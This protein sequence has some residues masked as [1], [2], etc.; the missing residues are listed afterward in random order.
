LFLVAL[1]GCHNEELKEWDGGFEDHWLTPT[2]R[3]ATL[4][5]G[6]ENVW[7][8]DLRVGY[9]A[10]IEVTKS[11]GDLKLSLRSPDEEVEIDWDC[12]DLSGNSYA[13]ARFSWVSDRDGVWRVRVSTP[14][15][16]ASASYALRLARLAP[17]R[18]AERLEW[19]VAKHR[20][21]LGRK[22]QLGDMAGARS[23]FD[24]ALAAKE[25]L[26]ADAP[27]EVAEFLRRSAISFYFAPVASEEPRRVAE[28]LFLRVLAIRVQELGAEDLEVASSH[29]TLAHLYYDLD[30]WSPA[31]EHELRALEIRRRQLPPD[32][33]LIAKSLFGLA[34]ITLRQGRYSS[35]A[36]LIDR[37]LA[38]YLRSAAPDAKSIA[39]CFN[40]KAEVLRIQDAL[41]AAEVAY[42]EGLAIARRGYSDHDRVVLNLLNN[43]A[44]LLKDQ[45]R[46][47]EAE[48]LFRRVSEAYAE[49]A[50]GQPREYARAL[51]NRAELLRL[52]GRYEE[53]LPLYLEALQR[54]RKLFEADDPQL[55]YYLNQLAVQ[56]AAQGRFFAAEPFYREI[57]D[58]RRRS[59]PE[60]HPLTSQSLHDY[61]NLL[62]SLGRYPEAD[63]CYRQAVEIRAEVF[64]PDHPEV[65]CSMIESARNHLLAGESVKALERV[66][67]AIRILATTRSFPQFEIEAL[68]VRATLLERLRGRSAAM[69][70][71]TAALDLVEQQRPQIGG[72]EIN[73][74]QYL[75]LHYELFHRMFVWQ[76]ES[77]DM[78]AAFET[79]ERARARV[80]LDRIVGNRVNLRQE[81]PASV[82]EPLESREKRLKS[83]LVALQQRLDQAGVGD[84]RRDSRR[85]A[86][87]LQ[88]RLDG[89]TRSL[90]DVRRELLMASP[91]WNKV[92]TT[93]GRPVSLAEAQ[94]SLVPADGL[95]LAYRIG[96]ESS[97]VLVIP[98]HPEPVEARKLWFPNDPSA[99]ALP[100]RVALDAAGLE[101]LVLMRELPD[102]EQSTGTVTGQDRSDRAV[103]GQ[104]LSL[105]EKQARLHRLWIT[106]IPEDL[107]PRI[108]AAKEL[109]LVPDGVLHLL[110]F[111][112]LVVNREAGGNVA[113]WLDRG[114]PI[115]YVSSA[116]T[117][118]NL[119]RRSASTVSRNTLLLVSDPLF[120]GLPRL[121]ESVEEAR[122]IRQVFAEREGLEI[123]TLT[124]LDARESRVRRALESQPRFL[125]F[126]T[127]G[128]VDRSR[129]EERAALALTPPPGVAESL[130][131]DGQLQL[132][133]IYELRLQADLA[134]LSAC[135][136][137][138]GR[139]LDGEGVFTLS[140]GFLAA[141]AARVIGSLW[142]VVDTSTSELMA[143]LYR[144]IADAGA[145][146]GSFGYATA[147]R[148]A[149]RTLRRRPEWSDPF[150]WAPFILIG[151][152]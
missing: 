7:N 31:E 56:Y 93:A 24:R 146:G 94:R 90:Q 18:P 38:I 59:L 96:G 4:T 87:S 117:A 29:A 70:S 79:L 72:G 108:L 48:Q 144:R 57:L 95:L 10:E 2:A 151:D 58:V 42:R 28:T 99:T 143:D 89:L 1:A 118:Y 120:D 3:D 12:A 113:Y 32:D 69:P 65:A 97:Y 17:A 35:A 5:F 73:R 36:A 84:R 20:A 21:L 14:A 23:A 88:S 105:S 19:E 50:E 41:D 33:P 44:G 112:A 15:S 150:Y 68:A 91:L 26:A 127:H 81:I 53:A 40:L 116:T 8:L 104:R 64:G 92:I 47:A 11:S 30:L 55:I 86:R 115:R 109:V 111:E 103:A 121:R 61:G 147:L 126:A 75:A 6:E 82:R 135:E 125:H 141:G 114:P 43:L 134:V 60:V 122:R 37:A 110:P 98:P 145:A 149:K 16:A 130:E 85:E 119:L 78:P 107:R 51:L 9:V 137:H 101:R 124:Q 140:E 63:S 67:H 148:D 71:L 106:L 128:I 136:S 152:H 139:R 45:G 34:T 22:L 13:T 123:E 49:Q 80:L 27:L 133:E 138:V 39:D 100:E 102:P 77:G 66:E 142:P 25:E 46:F 132:F 83:S 52:Q 74:A 131:D 76:V 129:N 62:R 54:A